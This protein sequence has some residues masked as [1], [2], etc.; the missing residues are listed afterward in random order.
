MTIWRA[1]KSSTLPQRELILVVLGHDEFISLKEN[2]RAKFRE[3]P[4]N[5]LRV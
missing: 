2:V 5:Y 3:I 4:T 1:D